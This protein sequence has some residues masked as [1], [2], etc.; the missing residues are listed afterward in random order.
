M[1]AFKLLIDTN[2][3]IG[4]EDPRR[5]DPDS[6]E[7]IRK[8]NENNVAIFVHEDAL[9]DI[10]RDKDITR[11]EI[12]LSKLRKFQELK[13]PKLPDQ[14]TLE[15]AFGPIRKANDEVDVALL[16]ALDIGAIDFLVTEDQGIHDRVKLT[17]LARRVFT[18]ADILTWLRRT[19][20]PT[21]VGLPLIEERKA[22]EIDLKD[23]IFD[24]LRQDYTPYDEWWLKTCV[25]A[26]RL[27]WTAVID[28]HLA[29]IVVRKDESQNEAG[30][31]LP[32]NKILK[33]CT[34][35]VHPNFRGEKL[36]ELLLKQ[37]LWFAQKNAYDLVYLTA[38][39]IQTL[40]IQVLGY[41]GF[42]H[43]HTRANGE[44]VLEKTVSRAR[45]SST[46]TTD[47]FTLARLNY[48]RF[49]ADPPAKVFVVPIQGPY[50][51]KLFPEIA[52]INPLPLFP[53]EA[54]IVP[55]PGE[56]KPGN[57]IRKVYLCRAKTNALSPGDILLFY[58]SKSDGFRA[59]QTITSIG[60]AEAITEA[61]RLDELIRLTAKR[62]VFS[63]SELKIMLEESDT[64]VRV[65]DF[66]LMSHIEPPISLQELIEAE[67]FN[68]RPPQSIS[69]I[70][71]RNFALIR[72]KLNLGFNV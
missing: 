9:R 30:T 3:F 50:H 34:F 44:L 58:M 5:V 18:V 39:P 33:I 69:L 61:N 72:A 62:S 54:L 71:R 6:A 60:V 64:P 59:S 26:H 66:L 38:F 37:V 13:A 21:P 67:V 12:S 52:F 28:G 32:G 8:C 27:C 63:E 49:S 22:H 65:I 40:L 46:G 17:S 10:S 7:L 20:D 19:F 14:S 15:A 31:K 35:K 41:Y 16:Y 29:G 43:T 11:R 55:M 48:P 42:Q 2:V 68:Q 56:R 24:S 25:P 51:Q 36:G 57:T 45:L 1:S 47:P 4:L 53:E 70:D 23:E